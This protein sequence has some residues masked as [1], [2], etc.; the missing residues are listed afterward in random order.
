LKTK[1]KVSAHSVTHEARV[2]FLD[3]AFVLCPPCGGLRTSLG[4]LRIRTL[5]L[6]KRLHLM[7]YSP[8]KDPTSYTT[9]LLGQDFHTLIWVEDT[10]TQSIAKTSPAAVSL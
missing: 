5:V 10:K 1:T 7:F 3:G 6:F 2:W 4:A 8:P 9:T